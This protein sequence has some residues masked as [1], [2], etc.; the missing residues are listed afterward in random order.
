MKKLRLELIIVILSLI[1]FISIFEEVN[2]QHKQDLND[3]IVEYNTPEVEQAINGSTVHISG[4]IRD[5]SPENFDDVLLNVYAIGSQG[6]TIASK[7][8]K[9]DRIDS[10]ANTDYNVTLENDSAVVAGDVRVMNATEIS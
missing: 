7:M 9:I 6:Q 2:Y 1:L 4:I 5:D 10:N 8:V 3:K